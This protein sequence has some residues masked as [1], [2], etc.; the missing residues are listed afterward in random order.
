MVIMYFSSADAEQQV[1]SSGKGSSV[2]QLEANLIK[3]GAEKETKHCSCT[4]NNREM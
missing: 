1:F 2:L 4:V 3:R